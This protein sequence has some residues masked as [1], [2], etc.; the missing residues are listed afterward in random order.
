MGISKKD[1]KGA[2]SPLVSFT[3]KTLMSV[4]TITLHVTAQE[5]VKMIEFSVF[6]RPAAYNVILGTLGCTR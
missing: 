2:P 4:F 1:I 6:D 5:V 3:S